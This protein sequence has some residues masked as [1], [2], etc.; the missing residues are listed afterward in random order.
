MPADV[1]L[2]QYY[3]LMYNS[4]LLFYILHV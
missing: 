1:S 4:F 2:N 3:I